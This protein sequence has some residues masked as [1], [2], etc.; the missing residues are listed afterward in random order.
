MRGLRTPQSRIQHK[1]FLCYFL[2]SIS[3]TGGFAAMV[4]YINQSDA[5][6]VAID[7]PS[8][9]FGEDNRKNDQIGRAH[10]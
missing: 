8:G 5:T 4:R 10:V 1:N 7:I 6:V 9:L 3:L 2:Y